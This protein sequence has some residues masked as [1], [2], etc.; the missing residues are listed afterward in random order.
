MSNADQIA[1]RCRRLIDLADEVLASHKPPP[2]GVISAG[3][4]DWETF[5]R[6][7]SSSLAFLEDVLGARHS[8]VAEFKEGTEHGPHGRG[9]TKQGRGVLVAV[10][11]DIEAG[12]LTSIRRLIR[13]E[14]FTDF[15]DMADHLHENGYHHA[16]VSLTGAVLEDGLR[17]LADAAGVKANR[18]DDL[19]ALNSKLLQAG[20]IDPLRRK[21]LGVWTDL[22]NASDHGDWDQVTEGRAGDMIRGVTSFLAAEMPKP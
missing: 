5:R 4:V 12:Y 7:R 17:Q 10:L 15:L 16:A 22:R 9:P 19:A 1:D 2:T 21:E 8:Y 13:A 20:A 11:D 14:V 6:W 18:R 3:Q